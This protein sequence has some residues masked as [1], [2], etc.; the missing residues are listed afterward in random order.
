MKHGAEMSEWTKAIV[1][2]ERVLVYQKPCADCGG[3][4]LATEHFGSLWAW[5]ENCTPTQEVSR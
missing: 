3:R 1:D 2:G 4:I 5:C